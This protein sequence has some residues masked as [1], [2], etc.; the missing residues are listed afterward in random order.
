MPGVEPGQKYIKN[1]TVGH[2]IGS[3]I[4]ADWR[5]LLTSKNETTQTYN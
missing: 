5:A 1:Q 4:F 2:P 3:P